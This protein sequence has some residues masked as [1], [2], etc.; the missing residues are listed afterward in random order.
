MGREEAEAE[1]LASRKRLADDPHAVDHVG[2][3]VRRDGHLDEIAPR[4][5][6]RGTSPATNTATSAGDEGPGS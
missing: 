3:P 2:T 5:A 1:V 6:G 4:P